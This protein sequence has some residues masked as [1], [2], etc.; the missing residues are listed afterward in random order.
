M[1][2]KKIFPKDHRYNKF[3]KE[4]SKITSYNI[5]NFK[6]NE[7]IQSI[8]E[9]VSKNFGD[10]YLKNIL[11]YENI[12]WDNIKK[13]NDLGNSKNYTFTIN[14]LNYELSP[15]TLRYVQFTLDILKHMKNKNIEEVDIVEI[16]G[17][18]GAQ[19]CFLYLLADSIKINSY[20]IL[21]LSE[22]NNLQKH[23]INLWDKNLNITCTTLENFTYNDENFLI[24]NYALGE[25]CK[26]T[27]N[28]YINNIVNKIDHGYICWNFSP[29]NQNIHEYFDNIDKELV[30]ENPQTNCP[31]VKTYNVLY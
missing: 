29:G 12:N 4:C 22:V 13:L 5:S 23:Y 9:N 10:M 3:C 24:S 11:Q 15:T 7:Y 1:K 14:N 27:Q 16:G 26:K 21:D 2:V 25:F 30:E 18:Y 28:V 31:P 8:V 20:T 19:S 17:G 6:G